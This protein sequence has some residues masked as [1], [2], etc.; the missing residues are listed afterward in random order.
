MASKALP[1]AH[2][3]NAGELSPLLGN[4]SDFAKYA[5]GAR[6]MRNFIPLPQG[7]AQK[8]SGFRHVA[9]VKNSAVRSWLV[10]F[11]FSQGDAW[12]IE[13]GDQTLRFYTDN[14]QVVESAKTITAI[15]KA[16]PGV[17]TS[18]AH[19]FSNGDEIV[20][21]S[22]GG[23]TELNGRNFI[24]A[25]VTANTFTLVDL[26]GVAVN[27][28]NFTTYTSGGTVSR[29]YTL[30]SPW[31][32]AT[33][34]RS[35]GTL[36]LS[37]SQSEDVI[38]VFM[39]G[40]V[41]RKLTRVASTNWTIT[42]VVFKNG[43]FKPVDPDNTITVYSGAATGTGQTLT[44]SSAI[45]TANHVG[46]LFLL[47]MKNADANGAWEA[48]KAFALNQ[49]VRS[50]GHW[51]KC[52]DAGTSGTITPSHT[53]GARFDGADVAAT[54][55]WEYQHSGYGWATI[56]AI[57]GGGT[58]ATVDI[59]S[60]IPDQAVGSGN[61]STKWAFGAWSQA[62]GWPTHVTFFRERLAVLRGSQAWFSVPADYENF[63]QRDAGVIAADSAFSVDFRSGSNDTIS[64]VMGA[65]DLLIGTEGGELS[66]SEITN[67]EPFGPGN[68]AP[69]A[70]P[71]FGSRR[72]MPVNVNES[73]FYVQNS[74][75]K[76]RELRYTSGSDGY[77]SFDRT[78]LSSHIA[79]GKIIQLAYQKEPN[80][81]IWGC[82][83]N[84]DLIGFTFEA[85]H[86][87]QGWHKHP[88]G[89]VFG[90]GQAVVES[91][92]VIPSPD[93]E[94]DQLWAIVKRTIN[95][96]TRRYV[97][98][99]EAEWDVDD[100]DEED[101]FFVDSGLTRSGAAATAISGLFHLEGQSV[102]ALAD[103]AIV[104]PYTVSNGAI[105]LGVAAAVT[106]AGLAYTATLQSMQLNQLGTVSRI[107]RGF[108]KL[109]GAVG[110]KFGP[111]E[112]N[113][114]RQTLPNE[115]AAID[116]ALPPY[117]GTA[118]LNWD[119]GHDRETYSTLVH[120]QPT[121]CIVLGVAPEVSTTTE[122]G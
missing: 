48:G 6:R 17:L 82:C 14:G 31:T 26:W 92:S 50:Q 11:V 67:S 118:L 76:L 73:A 66:I 39:D 62:E 20:I 35:D 40:Y 53:E 121:A 12:Q 113:T 64:W 54:C 103:G 55:Q 33:L 122:R 71:G 111:S 32:A 3:F 106:H 116:G 2:A 81:I 84:G 65:S 80:S 83:Q 120:D 119:G 22:I 57:G 100:D 63:A 41:P 46:S 18:N 117:T 27:T 36:A 75:K 89:G 68:A 38:Y 45:F 30:A 43:P 58:T 24:V 104:G 112:A 114:R 107:V 94:R 1:N 70:G 95:G 42:E 88:L 115:S 97:E 56:T 109:L 25:G 98:F 23:M 102:N 101:M 29:V 60:I 5:S 86:D 72:V 69:L 93:L 99:M 4:R 87:V 79:K 90:S 28:T 110:L 78:V 59:L 37:F 8:R 85:E 52:T 96:Q 34:E 15:T 47:E 91:I 16:S 21:A 74:G 61:A 77:S 44:A 51:Y 7:P 9:A 13:F 105:T 10:P 49:I 108:V 19:G